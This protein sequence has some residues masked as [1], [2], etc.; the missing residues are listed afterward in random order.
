MRF[1]RVDPVS[2]VLRGLQILFALLVL[3]LG[4]VS[5]A[6]LNGLQAYPAMGIVSGIFS[7]AFYI[8][9]LIPFTLQFFS[10]AVV[11]AGEIFTWLWWLIAMATTA[12]LFGGASCNYSY[13][14]FGFYYSAYG[15]SVGCKAGKAELAFA[16]LG[17]VLSI[18]TLVLLIINSIAPVVRTR[19]W[20]TR[21]YFMLGGIFPQAAAVGVVP[22]G[23]H[24]PEAGVGVRSVESGEEVKTTDATTHNESE[25]QLYGHDPVGTD[26][27]DAG[28]SQPGVTHPNP[29]SPH[30]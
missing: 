29:A 19:A 12:N 1:P 5:V 30:V 27:A 28:I 3:I 4:S 10:P 13:Y 17:W 25:Y 2:L 20:G 15:S 9:L 11:L 18:V 14:S 23:G 24:D 16:V 26:I 22:A 8:P 21:G 6:K 7:L